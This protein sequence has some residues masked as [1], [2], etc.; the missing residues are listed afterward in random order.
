[1]CLRWGMAIVSRICREGGE[2]RSRGSSSAGAAEA[3]AGVVSSKCTLGARAGGDGSLGSRVMSYRTPA[4]DVHAL[5]SGAFPTQT[6]A[7]A[8]R[9]ATRAVRASLDRRTLAPTGARQRRARAFSI[10][11]YHHL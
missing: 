3:G 9:S 2:P 10:T 6:N 8:P 1:M 11:Q 5:S 7:E 4:V